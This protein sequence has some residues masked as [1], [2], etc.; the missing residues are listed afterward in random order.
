[1]RP[2]RF[3]FKKGSLGSVEIS[4]YSFAMGGLLNSGS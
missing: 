3:L 1:M 4:V 2:Q